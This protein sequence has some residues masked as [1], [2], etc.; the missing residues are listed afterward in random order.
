MILQENHLHYPTVFAL[1]M[2]ILPIQDS[3][4]PCEQVFLSTKKT[5]TDC[6]SCILPELME[7]L[8]LFK[9]SVK[10]GCSTSFMAESSWNDEVAALEKLLKCDILNHYYSLIFIIPNIS[11]TNCSPH[12]MYSDNIINYQNIKHTSFL[13]CCDQ[14]REGTKESLRL[15]LMQ[16]WASSWM[17]GFKFFLKAS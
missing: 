6:W 12:L 10:H 15:A 7:G 9:Y 14:R 8:Q 13:Q 11:I 3:S 16:L 4:V 2:D 17:L 5:L 1:A